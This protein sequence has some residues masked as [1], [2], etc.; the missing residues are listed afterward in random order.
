[1][2]R[3]FIFI[4]LGFCFNQSL[5]A[6]E[7]DNKVC[8]I[9]TAPTEDFS[10]SCGTGFFIDDNTIVTAYHVIRDY[11]E[12]NTPLRIEYNNKIYNDV[13]VLFTKKYQDLAIISANIEGES[14][15]ALSDADPLINDEILSYGF[16]RGKWINHVSKGR[17]LGQAIATMNPK[18]NKEKY[19]IFTATNW[20]EPGMSGG[21]LVDKKN[22]V[23]GVISAKHI[24]IIE[25]YHVAKIHIKEALDQLMKDSL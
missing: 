21:P 7:N 14:W 22:R 18:E 2:I 24:S 1:M 25:S 12:N 15:F 5:I 23:I 3:I 8:L 6:N 16:A 9:R 13:Y 17:F 4:L 20:V 10:D 11:V 19:T